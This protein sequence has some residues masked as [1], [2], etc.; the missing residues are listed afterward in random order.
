MKQLLIIGLILGL[1][2]CSVRQ[3]Q[4]ADNKTFRKTFSKTEIKD[5]QLLFDFFNKSICSEEEA[6]DLTSCYKDFFKRMEKSEETGDIQ[7]N[8]PFGK[9]QKIY[10]QFSDSTFFEIWNYG[11]SYRHRDAP[12]DTFRTVYFAPDGKYLEFLKRTGKNDKV[13]ENYYESVVAAGD[14]PPSI[15]AGLLVNHKYYDIDD[16]RVKFIVAIHYLTLNDHFERKEKINK[17]SG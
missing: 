4:L 11:I 5:L 1:T 16:L 17:N 9:Q 13:I 14:I 15:I 7:L 8:I 2:N 3:D 6:Q 12:L 10:E